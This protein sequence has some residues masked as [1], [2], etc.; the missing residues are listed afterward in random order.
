[1]S[2]DLNIFSPEP[3]IDPMEQWTRRLNTCDQLGYEMHPGVRFEV[4]RFGFWPIKVT[5]PRRLM[6]P[7]RPEREYMSGFDM[8]LSEFCVENYFDLGGDDAED[9]KKKF[10]QEG[11]ELELWQDF[12]LQVSI[13]FKP[14]NAFEGALSF[15]SAAIL[16]DE[17]NGLCNDPQAGQYF[18]KSEMF[19]WAK[20]QIERNNKQVLK[21]QLV[22]HPFEG[23]K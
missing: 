18:N 13:S 11:I 8:S 2:Y 20:M 23:W 1:M 16:T 12:R 19:E 21:A 17:L 22:M 10:A 7:S 4:G 9:K 6:F 5:T 3:Q 15:L 14:T